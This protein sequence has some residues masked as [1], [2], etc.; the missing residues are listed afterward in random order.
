MDFSKYP[1]K[2]TFYLNDDTEITISETDMIFG[3]R[4]EKLLQFK[5]R[6]IKTL[7]QQG[8]RLAKCGHDTVISG[9]KLF[10]FFDSRMELGDN[11]ENDE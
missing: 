7:K 10:D 5:E 2:R 8:L 3:E 1:E 4:L 6:T 11:E 9:R